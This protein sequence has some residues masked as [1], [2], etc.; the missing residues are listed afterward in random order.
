MYQFGTVPKF[1]SAQALGAVDVE[2]TT[3][4]FGYWVV[5]RSGHVFSFGDAKY[6]GGAR[7]DGVGRDGHEHQLARQPVRATGCSRLAGACSACGDAHFYG[8]MSKVALN[9]PVL[10]SVATPSG[11]GY[12]MVASD[13][14]VF[15]FGDAKFE[16]STGSQ[17]PRGAGAHA[18]A[19]SRRRPAIGSSGTDGAVYSFKASFHGS[20]GGKHLNRPVVGM[21]SFGNGYLM[22]ASDGGIFNFSNKPFYG[23]LGSHPPP[24]PI[25][26]VAAYG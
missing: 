8:D 25:V 2:A 21:V 4:G 5:D 13:G 14:G 12:Y 24:I 22:V 3:S 1:G 7:I 26:S 10:D 16:G 17:T 20:M 18:H 9:G 11:H 6:F 19:R 23:S 15:T